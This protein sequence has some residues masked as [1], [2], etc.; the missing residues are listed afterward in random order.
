MLKSP[1]EIKDVLSRVDPEEAKF[2]AMFYENGIEEAL[3]WV[4]GELS[5]EDFE[6]AQMK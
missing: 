1:E 2:P 6:Y 5:D 4:L 3:M